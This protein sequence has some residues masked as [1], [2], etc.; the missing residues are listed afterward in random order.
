MPLLYLKAVPVQP[1]W[2]PTSIGFLRQDPAIYDCPVYTTTFRGNTYTFLATLKSEEPVS[3]WT[4][5]GV[6]LIM[7]GDE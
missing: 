2:I 4:L 7:Q 5:A 1:T 6:A 3:K